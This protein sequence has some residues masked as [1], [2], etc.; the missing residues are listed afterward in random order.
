MNPEQQWAGLMARVSDLAV[1]A[2]ILARRL[3]ERGEKDGFGAVFVADQ[4]EKAD[5]LRTEMTAFLVSR[6]DAAKSA[7]ATIPMKQ[8]R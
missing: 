5:K 1:D 6:V 8:A 3:V 4:L 7:P 2:F